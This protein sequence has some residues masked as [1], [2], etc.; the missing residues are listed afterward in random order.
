[1]ISK[2]TGYHY[3]WVVWNLTKG[4]EM[5]KLILLLIVGVFFISCS[6]DFMSRPSVYKNWDHTIYSWSGHK[7][8]DE[9]DAN[10]SNKQN[11]WGETQ[12]FEKT[13]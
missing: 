5:K 7:A 10:N 12:E 6:S 9:E 2:K 4:G 8:T 1:V 3:K 11:W 13:D